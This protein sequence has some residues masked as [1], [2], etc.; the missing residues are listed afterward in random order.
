[1]HSPMVGLEDLAVAKNLVTAFEEENHAHTAYLFYANRAEAEGFHAIAGL[2]RA[3][4]R[5]EQI[6]A[7]NHARVIRY[8]GGEAR[9]DTQG[10]H[11]ESTK[12]NLRTAL[13]DQRFETDYLYPAFLTAAVSLF[14]TTAVR[15]FRWA[16]EAD[17]SH[18]RLYADAMARMNSKDDRTW[19]QSK[20]DFYVCKLCGYTADKIEAENCPAC[21]FAWERFEVIN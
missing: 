9:G 17:K 20:R 12:E 19:A 7:N 11:V 21:N 8:M 6:H 4:A 18:A 10:V 14:D 2:F 5:A 13:G 1:M 16:L 3:T 15:T